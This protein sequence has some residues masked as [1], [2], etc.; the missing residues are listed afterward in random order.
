MVRYGIG[1]R[2]FAVLDVKSLPKLAAEAAADAL[3]PDAE[4][5]AEAAGLSW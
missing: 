4:A 1:C 5:A 3:P 2:Q